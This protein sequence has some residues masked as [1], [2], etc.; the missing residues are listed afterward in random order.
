MNIGMSSHT[1]PSHYL[2]WYKT[3]N[4]VF[5]QGCVCMCAHTHSHTHIC[6][7]ARAYTHTHTY[8]YIYHSIY[9]PDCS[10]L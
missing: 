2:N 8:I 1:L 5:V 10:T 6:T 9:I 7:H 3:P 4:S